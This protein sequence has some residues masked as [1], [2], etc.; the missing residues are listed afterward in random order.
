M[1]PTCNKQF[2]PSPA[3]FSMHFLNKRILAT[4]NSAIGACLVTWGVDY[5]PVDDHIFFFGMEEVCRVK[6]SL[7]TWNNQKS[8]EG[9]F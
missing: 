7:E 4:E 5:P 6:V 1:T 3:P 8:G 2:I 9:D